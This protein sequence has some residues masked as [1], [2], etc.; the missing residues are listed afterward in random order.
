MAY[1][2]GE[3]E[4]EAELEW[5][6]REG[7]QQGNLGDAA[8][9]RSP[10]ISPTGEHAAVT[11][12]EAGSGTLDLWIYEIER[13]LRTR[14]TFEAGNEFWPVWS[15][16]GDTLAFAA[17]PEAGPFDIYRKS[18]GG[19]GESELVYSS[20]VN[21]FPTSWSPDGKEL[22]FFQPGGEGQEMDIW[23]LP[24]DGTGE[25]RP[26]RQTQFF[27]VL[28]AFSPDGRWMTF[29]SN[30]SGEAQ[31]YVT[32]YPGPGRKWQISESS[33]SYYYW[34][35]DGR[36][37]VYVQNDG[38]LVAVEVDPSGDTFVIGRSRR[39]FQTAAPE[40]G[41]AFFTPTPDFQRFLS[42][43]SQDQQASSLI[44]LVV[45]WTAEIPG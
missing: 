42:A 3:A 34:R 28:P 12:R 18:V 45:N 29:I 5:L 22:A 37:I 31:L 33:G 13:D 2:T 4:V 1:Q 15:P 44:R 35:A 6:D 36:E 23:I 27:D 25:P 10:L 32:P 20:D 7:N 21:K 19:A 39:L 16:D 8:L 24:L 43:G 17:D 38:Q 41:G 11:I 30:E 40:I 9:Y 26:F 14:F